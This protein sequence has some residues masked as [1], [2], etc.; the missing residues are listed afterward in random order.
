MPIRLT[1]H[2]RPGSKKEE[3]EKISDSE[4][5]VKIRARPI[6]GQANERL[7]EYLAEEFKCAKS[8]IAIIKGA[9]SRTKLVEIQS[10][11]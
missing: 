9:T 10:I 7:I 2:L 6:D 1:I 3:I 4:W 11:E 5:K 8:K